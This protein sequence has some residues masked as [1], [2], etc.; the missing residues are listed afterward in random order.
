[1]LFVFIKN[2]QY[3]FRNIELE[4]GKNQINTIIYSGSYY[5]KNVLIKK[6]IIQLKNKRVFIY[7]RISMFEGHFMTDILLIRNNVNTRLENILKSIK[8]KKLLI[9][10]SNSDE[11]IKFYVEE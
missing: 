3:I 9:D 6:K 4:K 11:N 10:G 1:S 5:Y 2:Y 8:F 7:D